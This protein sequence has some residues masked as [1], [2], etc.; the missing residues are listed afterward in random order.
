LSKDN[1]LVD[2]L[3]NVGKDD[4]EE[5]DTKIGPKVGFSVAVP[6]KFG[7]EPITRWVQIA[8]FDERMR[9]DQ[10]GEMSPWQQSVLSRIKTGMKVGVKGVLTKGEYNGKTQYN[11]IAKQVFLLDPIA[12][13]G[14]TG[15]S[16]KKSTKAAKVEEEDDEEE[17]L[18]F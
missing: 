13:D 11:M 16:S 1:L 6:Q 2:I 17:D 14:K 9:D 4:A 5:F 3:G 18:G 8:V 12:R 7:E 10:D 15:T